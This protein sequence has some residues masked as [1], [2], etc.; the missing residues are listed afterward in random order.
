M[1]TETREP[2]TQSSAPAPSPVDRR[3]HLTVDRVYGWLEAG[4]IHEKE[5]VYLWKGWLVEKMAKNQPHSIALGSLQ[6]ALAPLVR[7]GYYLAIESPVALNEDSLPEPDVSIVRGAR[8]DYPR[9]APTA[10]DVALLIEVSDSSLAEDRGE[11]L[12][13]YAR[14]GVP[15]YWIVNI[16]ERRIEVYTEPTGPEAEPCYRSTRVHLPGEDVPVILDGREVGRVAVGA[17]LP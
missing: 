16:P 1:A 11:I 6:D 5:P 14:A 7:D 13:E 4:L 12:R 8:R 15:A 17:I 9:R 10:G 3:V 2:R